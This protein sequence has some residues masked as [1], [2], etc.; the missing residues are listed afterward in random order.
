MKEYLSLDTLP[1]ASEVKRN[2]SKKANKP[3]PAFTIA[4]WVVLGAIILYILYLLIV[5]PMPI[6]AARM[7]IVPNYTI[8]MYQ[9][10]QSGHITQYNKIRTVEVQDNLVHVTVFNRSNSFEKYEYYYE[11]DGDATYLHKQNE[12]GF[13]E[14][15]EIDSVQIQLGGGEDALG[16]DTLLNPFNYKRCSLWNIHALKDGIWPED[17]QKVTFSRSQGDSYEICVSDAEREAGSFYED[18]FGNTYQ[19]LNGYVRFTDFGKTKV[20]TPWKE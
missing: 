7:L 6:L 1:N 9:D 5:P 18:S 11:I 13:W 17:D 4:F 15:K 16:L 2:D 3:P 14:T 20:D 10:T 12:N 19:V 8:V